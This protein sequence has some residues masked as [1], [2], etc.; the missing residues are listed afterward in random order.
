MVFFVIY[1]AISK[2]FAIDICFRRHIICI[3]VVNIHYDTPKI[4]ELKKV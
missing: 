4:P 2:K 1:P 3:D